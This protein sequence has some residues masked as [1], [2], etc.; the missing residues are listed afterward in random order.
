MNPLIDA[1]REARRLTGLLRAMKQTALV[2]QSLAVES[3]LALLVS[4]GAEPDDLLGV[5]AV[6]DDLRQHL[7]TGTLGSLSHG[8]VARLEALVNDAFEMTT[9]PAA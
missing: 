9:P 3:S 6:V 4:A 5:L 7:P 1:W 2:E 8:R